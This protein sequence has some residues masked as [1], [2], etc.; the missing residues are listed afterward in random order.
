MQSGSGF[1]QPAKPTETE[2]ETSNCKQTTCCCRLNLSRLLIKVSFYVQT[3]SGLTTAN[4]R[5]D[6][7]LKAWVRTQDMHITMFSLSRTLQ[8]T[9]CNLLASPTTAKLYSTAHRLKLLCTQDSKS[10]T[11]E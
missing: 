2:S 8:T 3:A 10:C 4:L 7:T 5:T 9:K 1:L 6:L 11:Y